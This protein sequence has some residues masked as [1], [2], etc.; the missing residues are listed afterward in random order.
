MLKRKTRGVRM[1]G[2]GLPI[3]MPWETALVNQGEIFSCSDYKEDGDSTND[4]LIVVGSEVDVYF[5]TRIVSASSA[6]I[7]IFSEPEVSDNGTELS[8]F[9][10]NDRFEGINTP[11]VSIYSNP[12]LSS[13]GTRMETN[14]AGAGRRARAFGGAVNSITERLIDAGSR[15]LIRVSPTS[16]GEPIDFYVSFYEYEAAD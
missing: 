5:L 12:T 8:I 2:Y 16:T 3:K 14:F 1:D 7:A 11:H 9:N 10:R 13:D 6:S 4:W 15:Y